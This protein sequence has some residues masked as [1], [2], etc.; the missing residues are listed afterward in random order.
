MTTSST[1]IRRSTLDASRSRG[2]L[3][4]APIALATLAVVL[5]P[6]AVSA[7]AQ[8]K[9]A[10]PPVKPDAPAR[11]A[12]GGETGTGG[13]GTGTG[14]PARDVKRPTGENSN[15]TNRP[16]RDRQRPTPSATAEGAGAAAPSAAAP[17]QDVPASAR[18][19]RFEPE[20]VDFGEMIAGVA[21][22][23]PVKIINASDKP[24]TIVR[25]I[26]S[27]G[28]TTPVWPKDPIA[29]GESAEMQVTMRPPETQGQNL[30]K[31]VTLQLDGGLP[32]VVLDLKGH[33]AE[34]IKI[35][36]T[37]IDAP[38]KDETKDGL[39]TLTAVDGSPFK[40][41]GANPPVVKDLSDESKAEHQVHI[42]WPTWI[43]AG[44]PPKLAFTTDHPKATT[45]TVIV[46][47]SIRDQ[48]PVPPAAPRT[49]PNAA[50][51]NPLV[52]AVLADD[53]TT[54]KLLLANG[55]DVNTVD[56]V[57]GNR[58]ALHWAVKEGKKNLIPILLDA[59][60]NLE[61][62]DRVGKTPLTFAAEGRDLELV[63]MLVE[64]GADVNTR[65]TIQGS[66]L[67]WA[68]GLG[69]PEIVKF[70]IEKKA[71]VNV[72][73]VNGLTPLLWASGIGSAESVEALLKA[74]ARTDVADRMSGDTALMRAARTGR[75]ESL[76]LLIA[77][78][79]DVNAKNQ[80]GQTAF[81]LA[82]ASGSV[83]KLEALKKAGAD[84]AAKDVRGWNALDHANNRIDSEKPKVVTYLKEFVPASG[85]IIAPNTPATPTPT[86]TPTGATA[87]AK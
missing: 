40:I 69:T 4:I 52:Q 13:T 86:T 18:P 10:Q 87:P 1:Q 85:A 23:L 51:T 46:R 30:N 26:P 32:P 67:L 43:E 37:M 68:S 39:I 35:A 71:E 15:L 3:F 25:A 55:T 80:A 8:D 45:M 63:K 31:K 6:V 47:R 76:N 64:R 21:S 70:L 66:P 62:R 41:V 2:W 50:S 22:T 81:M 84:V 79:A 54:L 61:A 5:G 73:D 75:L 78:K 34:Y 12:T 11:P 29:P 65:D 53:A 58:T 56:T 24:V 38:G 57:G 72:V 14:A 60:A 42:D 36:P 27:C 82:A 48:Q 19:L 44:R 16:T 28:C 9:P 49:A 59:K 83:E 77:G 33:V 20:V 7:S 17:S 74:G